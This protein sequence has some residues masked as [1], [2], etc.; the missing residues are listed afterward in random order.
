M[1]NI[2]TILLIGTAVCSNAQVIVGDAVGTAAVKTSVLLDFAPNENKGIILPYVRT[3]PTAPAEGTLILD[4]TDATKARVKYY[5]GAWID[6]SGQ[7]ADVSAALATQ[8]TV[9]QIAEGAGEKVIIGAASSA[10]NGVLVLESTT[11]AMVLPTVQDV[12][13]IPSPSAGMMVYIN[14]EGAKRLAVFNGSKWSYWKP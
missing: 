10:A 8:P 1:K 13:N 5:N 2:L 7:D 14:K 3:L 11:K 12:Q 9:S 6:L 4:A